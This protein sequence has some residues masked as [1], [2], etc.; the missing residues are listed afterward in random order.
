MDCEYI[1]ID[2]DQNYIDISR[3]RIAAHYEAT[4]RTVGVLF[5]KEKQ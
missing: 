5:E 2:V 3:Q 1:G 4:H